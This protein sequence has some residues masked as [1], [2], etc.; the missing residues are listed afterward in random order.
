MLPRL[1]KVEIL[2]TDGEREQFELIGNL[3][4]VPIADVI[5][6]SALNGYEDFKAI[7]VKDL[8]ARA[9]EMPDPFDEPATIERSMV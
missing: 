8:V 7:V 2:L 1:T 6:E 5:K 9:H 4:G 3:L